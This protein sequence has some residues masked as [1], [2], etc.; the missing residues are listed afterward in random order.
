MLATVPGGNLQNIENLK[1]EDGKWEIVS[2]WKISELKQFFFLSGKGREFELFFDFT[3]TFPTDATDTQWA[4]FSPSRSQTLPLLPEAFDRSSPRRLIQDST[5]IGLTRNG[6]KQTGSH[7]LLRAFK[8][9]RRDTI[10]DVPTKHSRVPVQ[11]I[12]R[13]LRWRGRTKIFILNPFTLAIFFLRPLRD[14]TVKKPS[15]SP[16]GLLSSSVVSIP[17]VKDHLERAVAQP[18]HP[19]PPQPDHTE[20]ATHSGG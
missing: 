17:S 20:L 4:I 1:R 13:K 10:K 19:F 18:F 2:F 7:I 16:K 8:L 14:K 9:I 15:E 6:L 12:T 11:N 3:L 5:I